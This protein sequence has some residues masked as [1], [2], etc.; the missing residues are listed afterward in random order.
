MRIVAIQVTRDG[1]R[2]GTATCFDDPGGDRQ[3][4]AS[5][6]GIGA[7]VD[8]GFLANVIPVDKGTRTFPQMA[9]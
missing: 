9:A 1:M 5:A 4:P 8:W 6:G 2:P 7:E 3:P